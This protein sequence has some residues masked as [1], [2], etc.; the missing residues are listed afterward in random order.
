MSNCVS[1]VHFAK[2]IFYLHWKFSRNNSVV[3]KWALIRSLLC[4]MLDYILETGLEFLFKKPN[5]CDP[6]RF[7]NLEVSVRFLSKVFEFCQAFH[8]QGDSLL[9][10]W[11]SFQSLV[12]RYQHKAQSFTSSSNHKSEEKVSLSFPELTRFLY[13]IWMSFSD[14]DNE[15]SRSKYFRTHIIHYS[16]NL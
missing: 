4:F 1:Q 16:I 15:L 11:C 9:V 2:Q 10:G 6:F 14:S 12:E 5:F 13:S 3:F 7:Q 8:W